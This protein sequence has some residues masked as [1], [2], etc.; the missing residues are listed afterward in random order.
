[1]S[2][3]NVVIHA[4]N[5]SING[6]TFDSAIFSSTVYAGKKAYDD[7]TL[8]ST[9]LEENGIKSVEEVSLRFEI[10]DPSTYATIDKSDEITFKTK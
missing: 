8:F 4:E 3:R 1:M 10:M 7:I 9:E 2:P 5:V 6:F